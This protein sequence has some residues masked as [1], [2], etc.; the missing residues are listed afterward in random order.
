[1]VNA[2]V[3]TR[4]LYVGLVVLVAAERL[5]ELALSSS[6]ARR[7]IRRGGVEVGQAHYPWMVAVHATLLVACPLEVFLAQ[8][9]FL[10]WLAAPMLVLLVLTMGLRYW[11]VVTLGERWSTRVICLPGQP[12]VAT[13]PF[14]YLRHP[15]YVAV[16][17]ELLALPLVHTA[18][19]TAIACAAANGLVLRTRV[20]VENAALERCALPAQDAP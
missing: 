5:V 15:N 6:H 18:W 1:V 2:S 19:V 13:G 8:R 11:V 7:L 16:V 10:P 3:D 12:L 14:R 17:L 9:P 4:W 20:R